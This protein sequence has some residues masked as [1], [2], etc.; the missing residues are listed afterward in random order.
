[1][2]TL[3]ACMEGI[4]YRA[5]YNPDVY[6]EGIAEVPVSAVCYD[7]RAVGPDALFC[8]FPG[9]KTDGHAYAASA[10]ANGART[11]L[12]EHDLISAG[13]L[14]PEATDAICLVVEETRL[15]MAVA[16]AN[17]FGNPQRGL[18]II[19][20]TGT[21]GKTTI[22]YMVEAILRAAGYKVGVM[23]TIGAHIVTDEGTLTHPMEHTTPEAPDSFAI[24]RWMADNGVDYVMMEV[25]SHALWQHRCYGIRYVVAGMTVMGFDHLGIGGHPTYE[26][27]MQSKQL[28]FTRCDTAVLNADDW[29]YA[30]FRAACTAK[31][32]VPYSFSEAT[33]IV[34]SSHPLQTSFDALGTHFVLPLPGDVSVAN[35]LCAVKMCMAPGVDVSLEIAARGLANAVIPGRF[36]VVPTAREDVMFVVDFAH[37]RV[38]VEAA[39]DALRAMGPKRVV[40]LFGSVG[41]RAQMRRRELAEAS[42]KAD[43]V[44]ITSDDPG[45]EDPQAIADEIEGY[46][47]DVPHEKIVDRWEAVEWVALNAQPG[48]MVL[49]AGKGHERFMDI[50]GKRY[51]FSEREILQRVCGMPE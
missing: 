13:Q 35:A 48:D 45:F 51:P 34:R 12:C 46:L 20:I 37:N 40:C 18:K 36:E 21:K 50:A 17:F 10:Y 29:K 3:G 41:D 15:A 42:R 44:V 1:M 47:G 33:D 8:C 25:S 7:S 2:N 38:S 24:L 16:A 11:F 9:Q 27:Y 49:L 32:I 19:G 6:G 26:H 31:S 39:I 22:S 30:E 5:I 28:L 4:G 43:F 23:G 14:P